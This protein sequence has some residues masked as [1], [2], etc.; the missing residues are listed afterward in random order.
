MAKKLYFKNYSHTIDKYWETGP[1][2]ICLKCL[3]YRHISYRGCLRPSKYY[4][5]T[6]NHKTKDYKY[7]IIGYLILA[8]KDKNE[9]LTRIEIS[10]I[11]W[12]LVSKGI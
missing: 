6:S 12:G 9:K 5:Y 7:L 8:K 3:K 1:E 11:V 10:L 2:E 4:I